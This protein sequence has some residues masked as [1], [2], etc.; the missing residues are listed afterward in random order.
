MQEQILDLLKSKDYLQV[1]EIT[2]K[3]GV[4]SATVRRHLRKLEQQ[5]LVRRTHGG[6][7]R[8][9]PAQPELP[10]NLRTA[11]NAN[12]KEAIGRTAAALVEPGDTV[13][14]GSGST[15]L[16]VAY[17]LIGR[18]DLTVITNSLPI[19]NAL[20]QDEN[21][22]LVCPGGLLRHSESSFIGYLTESALQILRPKKVIIGIRAVSIT[23]GLTNDHLPEISTDRIIIKSAPEVIL[24]ADHTKFGKIATTVVAPVTSVNKIVTDS[25]T[26]IEIISELEK[27]GIEVILAK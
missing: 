6:V 21:I 19:L 18:K 13:F 5:N 7:M 14:I 2:S 11:V 16:C 1:S 12:E 10:I 17:N 23:D 26:S 20:A 9:Q 25:G 22:D 4:S 15:A 24:I 3:L 8:I 27:L